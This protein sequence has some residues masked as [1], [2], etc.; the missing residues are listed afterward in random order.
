MLRQALFIT[1]LGVLLSSLGGCTYIG[2]NYEEPQVELTGVELIR[3]RLWSQDFVLHFRVQNPNDST[4]PVRSLAYTVYLNDLLLSQGVTNLHSSV[5]AN[6]RR[7]FSVPV[8]TNL[9]RYVK[10]V[11]RML[12]NPNEPINYRLRGRVKTGWLFGRSV[13]FSRQ[14][15]F[16]PGA[17]IPEL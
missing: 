14:G 8:Q 4:L 17:Y 15:Q 16:V 12:E 11:G 6:G 5:P 3:A 7:S 1:L 13:H 10:D 9:W 2:H